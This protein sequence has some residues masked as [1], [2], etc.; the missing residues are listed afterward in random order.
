MQGTPN[1]RRHPVADD[2]LVFP[3]ALLTDSDMLAALHDH[4]ARRV[5]KVVFRSN[6][7]RL[8]SLSADHRTVNLHSCFRSAPADV[9]RALAD[10]V[11]E[12]S[13]THRYRAAVERMRAFWEGQTGGGPVPAWEENGGR[14]RTVPCCGTKAQKEL[15][16]ELYGSLNEELF[17][18]RLP[19][20][21]P[22]R[23][24]DR[25]T[26]RFGQ[27]H[28]LTRPSGRR[29]VEEIAL[30]VDLML[31]GNERHLV[32]TLLHE[33]A[34]AEA[35]IQSAHRGH[36]PVWAAIARRVGCE[37]RACSGVRIRRRSNGKPVTDVPAVLP[38]R[39]RSA[40][41]GGD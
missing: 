41:A 14:S 7:T 2:Q 39:R 16:R 40:A 10:F 11:L 25:M 17:E 32:D 34:H 37:D 12:R 33:M 21:L 31:R 5:T 27:I 28:Y 22:L 6:R 8:I 24:S 38:L 35:W 3:L 18:G 23:L 9:I 30:N 36:G 4:G 20:G 1:A 13:G 15:L 26:R 29:L 19:T